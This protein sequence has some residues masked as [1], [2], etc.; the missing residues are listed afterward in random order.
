[1]DIKKQILM[2]IAAETIAQG[3]QPYTFKGV[4]DA[5]GEVF[6]IEELKII[7]TKI[8]QLKGEG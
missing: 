4:K 1:M 3:D 8:K 6:T 7:R 5:T 2:N